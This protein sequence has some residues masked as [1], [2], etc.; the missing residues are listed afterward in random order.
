MVI[1]NKILVLVYRRFNENLKFLALR[2]NPKDPRH[3]GDFWYVITGGVEGTESLEEAVKRE[4]FEETGITNTLSIQNM[5]IVYE[6]SGRDPEVL[7]KEYAFIAEVSEDVKSLNEEHV[8]YEWLS[9]DNFIERI[10][11]E[12]DDLKTFIQ[13]AY[14]E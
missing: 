12:G 5:E 9:K 1:K 6:Y 3:G 7:F 2:N 4:L 14:G 10:K 11:W 8:E 13:K